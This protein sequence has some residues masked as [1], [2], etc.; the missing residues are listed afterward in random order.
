[1][2]SCAAHGEVL[3]AVALGSRSP[4]IEQISARRGLGILLVSHDL[5][6]VRRLTRSV[7]VMRDGVVVEQGPTAEVLSRPRS[8]HTRE[9]LAAE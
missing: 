9:L 2:G 1:L 7:L 8:G 4:L 6:P 3:V 5:E